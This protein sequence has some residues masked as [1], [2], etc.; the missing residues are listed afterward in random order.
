[1]KKELKSRAVHRLKVIEGQV[2]GIRAMVEQ[3]K[4]CVDIINQI[5]AVKKALG[6]T[7]DLLLENHLSTHV[8]HQMRGGYEKKAIREV[9]AV[10]K[11]SARR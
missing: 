8:M 6:S 5:E 2:R 9:L 7:A 4:Y 3:E 10:Y 11:L 1:M